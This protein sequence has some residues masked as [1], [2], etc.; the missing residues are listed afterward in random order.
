[1]KKITALTAIVLSA[2]LM[3]CSCGANIVGVWTS[4]GEVFGSE[5]TL[6]TYE[7][8]KDGTYKYTGAL[9]IEADGTYEI[10]GDTITLTSVNFG[11]ESKTTYTFTKEKNVL[12]LTDSNGTVTVYEAKE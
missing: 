9:G 7:F 11:V 6:S 8:N 12:K 2:M 5:I 3:L 4:T 1:M 10:D